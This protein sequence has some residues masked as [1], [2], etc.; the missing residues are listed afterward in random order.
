MIWLTHQTVTKRIV[1]E[2]SENYN[3]LSP[4]KC[5][6]LK[7]SAVAALAYGGSH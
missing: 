3:E 6:E 2:H 5:K 7:F 1:P 4:K